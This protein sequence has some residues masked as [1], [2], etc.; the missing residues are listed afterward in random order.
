MPDRERIQDVRVGHIGSY[1]HVSFTPQTGFRSV[2]EGIKRT[3]NDVVGNRDHAN[4]FSMS[5]RETYWPRFSGEWY[6]SGNLIVGAYSM[7]ASHMAPEASDPGSYYGGISP[8]DKNNLAWEILSKTNPNVPDVSVPT[9]IGELKDLPSLVRDWGGDLL[10]KVAKGHLS[11]RWAI[12][13]MIGDLQKLCQFHD[14]VE[15]RLRELK[16]LQKKKELR[17]RCSLGSDKH[18]TDWGTEFPIESVVF[19]AKAEARTHHQM[20][21]WGSASFKVDP[22][23]VFPKS[24][25]D[26]T[27]LARRLT[28]GITSYD[29]LATAWELCPWSW[30]ADWFLGIGDVINACR[31]TVPCTW[32]SICV[33]RT[34]SVK[35]EFRI[36]SVPWWITNVEGVPLGKW[37]RKERH[38]VYP[39][40]P[41]S[42][43]LPLLD[44]GKWSVLASLA[45]LKRK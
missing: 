7:P 32:G 24:R 45:A 6:D 13:P 31:N 23:F 1:Y 17:K 33:M 14:L 40:L 29:A 34:L 16:N 30:F 11:W 35:N 5:E 10:K 44:R 28:L 37:I 2:S 19:T 15:K 39:I 22:S 4:D 3:T 20:K 12:K 36:T 18:S 21:M 9:A 41:F 43:S 27:S 8:L 42:L 26:L 38:V 25:A